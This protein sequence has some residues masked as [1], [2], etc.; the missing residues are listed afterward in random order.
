M[1][2]WPRE[3]CF[4]LLQRASFEGLAAGLMWKLQLRVP[5]PQLPEGRVSSGA[6][7]PPRQELSGLMLI[8]WAGLPGKS[9]NN[10]KEGH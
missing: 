1:T 10:Y 6:W 7:H 8:R 5:A 9:L 3:T 4:L 2:L